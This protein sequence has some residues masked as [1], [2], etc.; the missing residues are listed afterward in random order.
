[1]EEI[2]WKKI[3]YN[4]VRKKN[5]E[6]KVG[7]YLEKVNGEGK[8]K[9]GKYSEKEDMFLWR[10]RKT[11][12]EKEENIWMRNKI[13]GGGKYFFVVKEKKEK[14][15]KNRCRLVSV[16]R[17]KGFLAMPNMQCYLNLKLRK[18]TKYHL[19]TL[20]TDPSTQTRT[21]TTTIC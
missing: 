3:Y 21:E 12:K 8:R 13:Y 5:R 6:G 10:S 11:E 19:P 20:I 18:T 2:K 15:E 17:D 1:M 9:G 14:K 7:K 4:A 16:G